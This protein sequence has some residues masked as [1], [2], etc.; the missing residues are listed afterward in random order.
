MAEREG[1]G[2]GDKRARKGETDEEVGG[3]DLSLHSSKLLWV[4]RPLLQP[5]L[6][7]TS[8][9]YIL[10]ILLHLHLKGWRRLKREDIMT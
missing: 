8:L 3:A 4:T 1:K 2:R 9:V 7:A 6:Q 5:W 10:Y